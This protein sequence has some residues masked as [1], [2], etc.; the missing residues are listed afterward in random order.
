MNTNQLSSMSRIM[1]QKIEI[2]L[3]IKLLQH[4]TI[5]QMKD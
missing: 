5:K 4:K 2:F 3:I 1:A